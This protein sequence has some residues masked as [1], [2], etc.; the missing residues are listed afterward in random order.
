MRRTVLTLAATLIAASPVAADSLSDRV[1]RL[2]MLEHA[3]EVCGTD[4]RARIRDDFAEA[5]AKYDLNFDQLMARVV[6]EL[7]ALRAYVRENPSEETRLCAALE[8]SR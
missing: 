8:A 5:V 2:A 3:G 4:T 6:A 1:M 7:A